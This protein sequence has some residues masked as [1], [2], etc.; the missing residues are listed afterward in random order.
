MAT[1]LAAAASVV[2]QLLVTAKSPLAV[3]EE[4][5]AGAVPTF[6]SVTL[7]V[8]G[9]LYG[10]TAKVGVSGENAMYGAS[11]GLVMDCPSRTA[12]ARKP[13]LLVR[14]LICSPPSRNKAVVVPF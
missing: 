8:V 6:L 3:I 5:V 13:T 2:P 1:Q 10:V 4:M 12:Q 14:A 9:V 11:G 7:P